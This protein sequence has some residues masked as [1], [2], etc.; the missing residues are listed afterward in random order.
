MLLNKR[1]LLVGIGCGLFLIFLTLYCQTAYQG[2]IPY[3]DAT[4]DS[5][6]LQRVA[7]RL[8]VAHSTGYPLFTIMGYLLARVG[9]GLGANPYT[10]ITY[11]S[12]VWG[13]GVQSLGGIVFRDG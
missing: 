13:A 3:S 7:N 2:M 8:G 9:E 6:E 5:A 10:W 1:Y 12:A 11:V 4:G